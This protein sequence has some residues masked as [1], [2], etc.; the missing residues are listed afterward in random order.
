MA[1]TSISVLAMLFPLF[2]RF[3]AM[4]PTTTLMS[5]P[6]QDEVRPHPQLPR[7]PTMGALQQPQ[8]LLAPSKPSLQCPL[9]L[10]P[11][12]GTSGPP[13]FDPGAFTPPESP[14]APGAPQ[15]PLCPPGAL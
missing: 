4:P 8:A 6:S 1:T 11:F 12:H 15:L 7:G 13:P 2:Q 14:W 9:G 5:H 3:L 10:L